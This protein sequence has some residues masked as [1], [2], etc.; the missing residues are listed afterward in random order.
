V[1]RRCEPLTTPAIFLRVAFVSLT[2]LVYVAA[3]AHGQI[4][5]FGKKEGFGLSK[6]KVTLHRKLPA[7]VHLTTKTFSVQAV[8][9][10]HNQAEVAQVLGDIL[11]NTLI[12]NNHDL[13]PVKTSPAL[14]ITCTIT[15]YET[16]PPQSFVRTEPR[17]INNKIVDVNVTYDHY[18]G[19]VDVTYRAALASG[20]ILDSDNVSAKYGQDFERGTNQPSQKQDMLGRFNPFGKKEKT[21]SSP[22]V[23]ESEHPPTPEQL[24]Q[25][26]LQSLAFQI[27]SRLVNTDEPVEVLLAK[28]KN[29]DANK[30][31]KS[32][33]WSRDLETLETTP[34][35]NNP[36][37]EAYRLYNIGVANE[38]LA[39]QT[40]DRAAAKKFLEEAAINYGK[41]IDDKPSEKYF[42]QPQNRIETAIAYYKKLD[43]REK[44]KEKPPLTNAGEKEQLTPTSPA[45]RADSDDQ[46]LTNEK[47]IEMFQTGVDEDTII[48]AIRT[49]AKF[50]LDTSPNAMITLAKAGIKG[51]IPAAMRERASRSSKPAPAKAIV[52]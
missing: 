33:L 52:K 20:K 31:A 19:A 49:E 42:L 5:G 47:I 8:S 9:H 15:H 48:H 11:E 51:K 17:Y 25:D 13:T 38:A 27:A 3:P 14:I 1:L 24:R 44:A 43:D 10:D 34:A 29:E 6:D 46:V 45:P 16:P 7:L 12:K 36:Q 4:L 22:G 18:S 41:A 37:E 40:E 21:P 30:L 26:L 28:G 50:K 32:G 2:L 23:E 35:S 39:Y